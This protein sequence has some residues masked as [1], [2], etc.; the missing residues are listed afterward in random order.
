MLIPYLNF[1][2]I[3][4]L[5]I[6]AVRKIGFVPRWTLDDQAEEQVKVVAAKDEAHA[7][8]T[9]ELRERLKAAEADRNELKEANAA[10]LK[11]QRDELGPALI[12]S[13]RIIARYVDALSRRGGDV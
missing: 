2:L 13:S 9:T 7:A 4:V 3:V 1:G 5:L 10:L 11:Y 8:I 12:E 6:M